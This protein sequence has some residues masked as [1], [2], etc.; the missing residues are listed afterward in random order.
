MTT[1]CLI[2][3]VISLI[4][5]VVFTALGKY[6]YNELFYVLALFSGMFC[7][8]TLIICMAIKTCPN[9]GCEYL[10]DS[11]EMYCRNCGTY[12]AKFEHCPKCNESVGVDDTYCHRCGYCLVEE[13][14]K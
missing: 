12:L 4:L 8:C 14:T 13:T 7:V 10:P 6:T 9:C 11:G 1:T 3:I 2:I 5:I